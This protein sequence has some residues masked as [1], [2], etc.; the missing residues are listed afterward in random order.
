MLEALQTRYADKKFA[1]GDSVS[2]AVGTWVIARFRPDSLE[3]EDRLPRPH[4]V[5]KGCD[6]P[7]TTMLHQGILNGSA[8][9]RSLGHHLYGYQ[10]QFDIGPVITPEEA[11][12]W[13]EEFESLKSAGKPALPA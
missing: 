8:D 12:Q 1:P 11:I 3:P 7:S 9:G 4:L 2:I 5:G 6:T 13:L 10:S